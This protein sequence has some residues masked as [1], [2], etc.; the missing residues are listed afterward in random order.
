MHEDVAVLAGLGLI[1][2]TARGGVVCPFVDI[3]VD[4]HLRE[5]V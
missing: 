3:H 2:R 5:A 4:M 1:E